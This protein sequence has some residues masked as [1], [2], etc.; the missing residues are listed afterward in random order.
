MEN[1][2]IYETMDQCVLDIMANTDAPY[3][4]ATLAAVY[5]FDLDW[6]YDNHPIDPRGILISRDFGADNPEIIHLC[7]E[8]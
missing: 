6:S 5:V 3:R 7:M 2:K 8:R 4:L 1:Q